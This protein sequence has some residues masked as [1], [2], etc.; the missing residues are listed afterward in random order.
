MGERI[1]W[2][3]ATS[4]SQG[5]RGKIEPKSWRTTINGVSVWVSKGHRYYPDFWIM[6]C[7]ALGMEE[8]QVGASSWDAEN[9]QAEALRMASKAARDLA[10]KLT[11][12]AIAAHEE[13]PDA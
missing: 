6:N 13:A 11:N 9:A 5:Q 3:D 2:K 4:Y 12:F 8:E 1:E 7:H 10:R